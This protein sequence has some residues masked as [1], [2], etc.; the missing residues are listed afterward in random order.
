MFDAEEKKHMLTDGFRLL[1]AQIPWISD[2]CMKN[3]QI[4]RVFVH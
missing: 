2:V 1:P 4:H 3:K